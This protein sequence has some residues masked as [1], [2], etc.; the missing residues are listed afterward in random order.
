MA[1]EP[2]D[3]DFEL[4]TEDR[5]VREKLKAALQPGAASLR[6]DAPSGTI[7]SVL[8]LWPSLSHGTRLEW[9][10]QLDRATIAELYRA[11]IARQPKVIEV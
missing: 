9:I 2:R 4:A 10:E 3:P 6:P 1:H 5:C 11:A 8:A 7:A